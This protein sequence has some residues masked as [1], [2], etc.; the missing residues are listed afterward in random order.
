M[1]FL[2]FLAVLPLCG[3]VTS[4]V[5][6]GHAADSSGRPVAGVLVRAERKSG[7]LVRES[8]TARDGTFTLAELEPA[9][10]RLTVSDE[11]FEPVFIDPVVVAV[12]SRRRV[13]VRLAVR[14]MAQTVEVS[15]R[16]AAV[17]AESSEL[18]LVLDR[19]RIQDLPLNRRDFLQLSLL[20]PGVAAPVQDSELSTRGSF[21]MHASGAR[22]EANNFLMDGVDNNDPYLNTFALQPPVDAIQEFKV[23]TSTHSALYGRSAGAQVNVITRG[24]GNQFHGS[25]YEFFRNRALDARNA[26]EGE[27]RRKLIRNQFGG[28]SGGALARDRTFYFVNLEALRERRG[29][30]RAS[31]VP[32]VPQREGVFAQTVVDPFTQRPFPGNVVPRSRISALAPRVL[33]LFPLP[34][35]PGTLN[36]LGQPVLSEALTQGHTRLDHQLTARDQLTFRYSIGVQDLFEP[37][38]EEL[39]ELPGFGNYVDNRGHNAMLHHSRVISPRTFHSLRLGFGRAFRQVRPENFARD[40]GREWG[41]PWLNVR[42]RD[43]GYPLFNVAG[44]PA[45]GDAA[46]LP[47]RRGTDTYQ[48]IQTMSLLRGPHNFQWGGEARHSRL[49]GYLDYFARGSLTFSGA[50]SG[51]GLADLLLGFPAFGIQAQFDN[52]Q[53][54]TSSAFHLFLQDDWRVTRSLT[55]NLGLRYELLTPPA[56][57]ED[58]MSILDPVSGR[59]VNVGREGISRS[60]LRADRNNLAPRVGFAWNPRGGLV[61]RGGYGMYYDSGLQVVNSSLYFNPPYF[62]VRVFFPTQTSLLTL[63]NPFAGGIAPPPSPNTLSP[64]LRA[65]YVQQWNFGLQQQVG[66]VS[67]V[68]LAYAG[69]KGSHLIRSRDLNQPRPAPGNLASRRPYPALGSIFYTESG[70]NSSYHSLQSSLDRRLARGLSLLASYTWSKSIDDASAFLGNRADKNFPQDSWNYRAERGLS[71]FD[72]AHRAAAAVVYLPP[73]RAWWRRNLELRTI[74]QAQSGQPFTPILR[75]DNSN[76]GN[77][78][79]IFGNDRPDLTRDPRLAER[80]AARWFD[81]AAF[82]IPAPFTFGNAGRN[83]VRAPG[84]ASLDAALARL[85]VLREGI[86][87]SADVQAFNLANRVNLD[88]PERFADEPST[89]GRILSAKAPRQVQFALRLSW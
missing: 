53:R 50:L 3:Q 41:V 74:L 26:F 58:R 72:A 52:R 87:L 48:L 67:T 62:S 40:V 79:G 60:G 7:G 76:T 61:V 84:F 64:D 11:R 14:G 86:W 77:T 73:G 70:A 12:N 80:S 27:E 78:G 24:G 33:D 82:A 71:S 30:S 45:A 2:F 46:Q 49:N 6:S 13:D 18:A 43:F 15:A 47:I 44:F 65:A 57:P 36:F 9:D 23:S 29:F 31:R 39:A 75:F 32:T 88:L 19:G 8:V 4:S 21:A 68:S 69:A 81:P 37:F 51:V 38:T 59:I 34:N 25:L 17:S 85:F 42:P 83:I 20:A 22:E 63:D 54:L 89:F 1:W 66:G 55:L 56:D 35:Q 5:I 28:A 16:A 10:Y